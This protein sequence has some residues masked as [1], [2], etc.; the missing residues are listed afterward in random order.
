MLGFTH[1]WIKASSKGPEIESA[2]SHNCAYQ[3]RPERYS[4][5]TVLTAAFQKL[6]QAG[7]EKAQLRSRQFA[8]PDP[9]LNFPTQIVLTTVQY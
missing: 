9:N 8:P 7:L 6:L 5:Q 1:F 4:T 2:L 3:M